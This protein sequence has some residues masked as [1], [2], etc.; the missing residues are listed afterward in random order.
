MKGATRVE[1]R[2]I[3]WMKT[4]FESLTAD[5][6]KEALADGSVAEGIFLLDVRRRTDYELS[7]IDGAVHAEA[8]SWDSP[9]SIEQYPGDRTI[10]VICYFGG[11]A[12]QTASG[13]R[14]L[15]FD[16]TVLEGGMYA[17]NGDDG[18]AAL[19]DS[20]AEI[21]FSLIEQSFMEDDSPLASAPAVTASIAPAPMAFT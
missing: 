21:D 9:E 11:V 12:A 15:G 14:Q 10:V 17:W 7:H 18:L 5:E 4:G 3:A 6:L 2:Q 13:L 8:C 16:A 1:A 19:S 20:N